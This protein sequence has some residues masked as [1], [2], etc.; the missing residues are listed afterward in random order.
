MITT[1]RL[2]IYQAL[3]HRQ[4]QNINKN[5][6][7][8]KIIF[9]SLCQETAVSI[10]IYCISFSNNLLHAL[11]FFFFLFMHR[12]IL[13]TTFHLKFFIN[14]IFPLFQ[15]EENATFEENEHNLPVVLTEDC[16]KYIDYLSPWLLNNDMH[17]FL[18]VGPDGCG[19]RFV[20]FTLQLHISS[21][22]KLSCV[23]LSKTI[24]LFTIFFSII[25]QLFLW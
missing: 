2:S 5:F 14:I 6:K 21:V 1:S 16:L 13:N 3:L 11:G 12:S 23:F 18:L 22:L 24:L 15:E 8:K 7:F 19:K 17:P 10:N 4:V 20:V 9:L 25:F